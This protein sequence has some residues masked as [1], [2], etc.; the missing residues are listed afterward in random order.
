MSG[1]PFD[2]GDG[3]MVRAY[4]IEDLDAIWGAIEQERDRIGPWMPWVESTVR[5]D[6]E[7]AWLE[8]IVAD[9]STEGLG[10]WVEGEF[11]GG[12]GLAAEPFGIAAEIG[13]WIRERFEGR[14]FVTR[15]CEALIG[16]AFDTLGVHRV[17]IR[18]GVENVRSRAIPERLGF[19]FEG[20]HREEGRGSR[21]FYDLNMYGLLDREWRQRG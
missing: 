3:A 21:G 18:A 5:R 2:L 10:I 12:I 1:P 17:A 16:Y 15:A 13:Y 7:R 19:T 11:A 6:D 9:R 8:R 20:I 4:R 14:G